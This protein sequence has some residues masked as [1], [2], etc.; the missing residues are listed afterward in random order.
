M[1]QRIVII[2][3]GSTG[4]EV[5]RRLGD[6]Y[7]VYL[8]DTQTRVSRDEE[9][10]AK[11]APGVGVHRLHAD[12]TSRLV[13]RDLFDEDISCSLVAMAGSDEIN[14]EVARLGKE[15]GYH[16]VVAVQYD[17]AKKDD[18]VAAQ[19]TALDRTRLLAGQVEQSIR[20]QGAVLPTGIGLGRGELIE[21]RLL[22]TSPVLDV[23]LCTLAPERWRVAAIFRDDALIVPTGDT[24]L[25]IDDRVL[26]VGDPNILPSVAEYLHLGL[27]Q[28]PHP[29]GPNFVTLERDGADEVLAREATALAE[30][31]GVTHVARGIPGAEDEAIACEHDDTLA[32]TGGKKSCVTFDLPRFDDARFAQQLERHRPGLALTRPY[33]RNIL[34]RLFGL[35]G[36]DAAL[37][38]ALRIPVLFVRGEPTFERILLPVSSARLNIDAA[39]LAIDLT[40]QMNAELTALNVDLPSYISGAE[41]EDAHNEVKPLRRLFDLYDVRYDYEHREGNPIAHLLQMAGENDLVVMA[42][43]RRRKDSFFDPDVALRMARRAPCSVL[44]LTIDR[45]KEPDAR[46]PS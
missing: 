9:A 3:A 43:Y 4:Q 15:L 35:R 40:R 21:I 27:P 46:R 26:L 22:R 19:V 30:G 29:Y 45:Q 18:Y 10:A 6:R 2:G 11:A 8:L 37:C 42:R 25:Q 7:E 1:A 23:P 38:D 16:P 17:S 24:R 34:A 13:L 44:V 36:D 31:C 32:H 33:E 5:A 14:L 28:F 41:E 39:E 12:G 20:H